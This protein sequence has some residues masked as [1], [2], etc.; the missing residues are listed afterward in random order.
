MNTQQGSETEVINRRYLTK[1]GFRLAMECP[2]K[3]FYTGKPEYANQE[4]DDKFLLALAD[5][6][7]Q[8]GELAKCY[9]PGGREI[10]AQDYQAAIDET[11]KLLTVIFTSVY[12]VNGFP[13]WWQF[14]DNRNI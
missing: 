3:L 7:F 2:T 4:L 5:G 12:R 9:F 8:V 14:V 1:S 10:K 13:T 11:K 6:G